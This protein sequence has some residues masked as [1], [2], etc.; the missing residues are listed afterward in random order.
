M[1][2]ECMKMNYMRMTNETSRKVIKKKKNHEAK[3]A[4]S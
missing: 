2:S 3:R 4:S 1:T